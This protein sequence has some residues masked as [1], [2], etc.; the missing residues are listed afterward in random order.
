MIRDTR[1]ITWKCDFC[2][3]KVSL[4]PEE[5]GGRLSM[6]AFSVKLFTYGDGYPDCEDIEDERHFCNDECLNMFLVKRM[7][8]KAFQ[9]KGAAL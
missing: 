1:R 6:P 9:G 8:K 3:T 5:E 4:Y 7:T 2:K